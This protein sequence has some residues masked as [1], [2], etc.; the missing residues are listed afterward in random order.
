[1]LKLFVALAFVAVVVGSFIAIFNAFSPSS[2]GGDELLVTNTP[3][4]TPSSFEDYLLSFYL[5]QHTGDLDAPAS[6]DATPVVFSI[7]PGE[8]PADVATRLQNQ[9]LIKDSDLFM[10]LAKYTQADIKIQAGEYVLRRTMKPP[11]ILEAI[12]HGR[13]KTIIV[14]VR[15]GWRAEEIADYLSTLGLQSFSKDEF[16]QLVKA[17]NVDYAFLKDRPKGASPSV[18][19]FL[20]PETYNVPYDVPTATLITLMLD[21]FNSRVTEATRQKA[22]AQKLT[23]YEVVTL[24][25]IVEREAVAADERPIIASVFLNR[26]KKKMLLQADSTAQYA[27]GYQTATKLW[28][29]SPVTIDELSNVNSPYNTYRNP[30]LPPGPISN[31]SLSSINA[32]A[33]PAQTDYLFYFSKGDGTH[34]FARTYEEHQ[35]NQARYGK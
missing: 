16:L 19:G 15:P 33:D 28:W 14:T 30:G 17:G 11:E 20:F 23:L 7:L 1:L 8:L 10:R 5:Q 29:K 22:A 6:D 26:I 27:I 25:S 12:Q 13:A 9:G 4:P 34:A 3:F 31:P 24:A 21:T 35:Q 18:E 2:R 32:A